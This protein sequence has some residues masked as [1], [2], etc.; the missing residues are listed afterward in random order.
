MVM[1]M[2]MGCD[3]WWG[4]WGGLMGPNFG[5]NLI[6]SLKPNK[7]TGT[8]P[9]C[10]PTW[11]A[12]WLRAK[13]IQIQIQINT[14]MKRR[15]AWFPFDKY[16]DKDNWLSSSLSSLLLCCLLVGCC[17]WNSQ[18]VVCQS[19]NRRKEVWP[20]HNFTKKICISFVLVGLVPD[21]RSSCGSWTG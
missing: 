19:P 12:A 20:A 9:P 13:Q 21:Y 3:A 8:L 5:V 14:R 4:Y 7:T 15:L 6:S 16:K 11:L 17:W 1:M 18:G 2:M 10:Q